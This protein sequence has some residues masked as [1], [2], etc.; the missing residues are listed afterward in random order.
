MT[1]D[2]GICIYVNI[3]KVECYSDNY[4]VTVLEKRNGP[5]KQELIGR[6]RLC[7]EFKAYFYLLP[8]C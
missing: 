7:R 2:T 1:R 4:A 3:D 8:L 6:G 5:G